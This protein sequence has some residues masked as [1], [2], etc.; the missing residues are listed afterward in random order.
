LQKLFLKR[1]GFFCA[2]KV[3]REV[4]PDD[5]KWISRTQ[6]LPLVG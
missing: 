5:T 2:F 1:K 6:A 3:G 4:Y